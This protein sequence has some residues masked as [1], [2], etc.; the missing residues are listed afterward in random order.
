MRRPD[1][2]TVS[3]PNAGR[4]LG[5]GRSTAYRLAREGSLP[6][7]KLGRKLRVPRAALEEMLRQPESYN[8][9]TEERQNN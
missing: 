6:V 1:D 9:S 7:L 4:I 5:I 3:V 2:A 8:N